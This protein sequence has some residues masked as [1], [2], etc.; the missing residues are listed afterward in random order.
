MLNRKLIMKVMISQ[1]SGHC[2]KYDGVHI[3]AVIYTSSKQSNL[4][5]LRCFIASGI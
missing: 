2:P 5:A 4:L 3:L 1:M